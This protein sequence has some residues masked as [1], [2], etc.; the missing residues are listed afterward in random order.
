[1][2]IAILET[3]K[4]HAGFE[5]V[6]DQII[7]DELKN[8]GHEPVLFLPENSTLDVDLGVPIEYMAGGSI[9]NY[10]NIGKIHKIWRMMQR[11]IRRIKWFNA[12]YAKAQNGEVDAIILTTATYRYLR[13]LRKSKLKN[14]PIPIIFIFLGVTPMEKPYFLRE[15]RKCVGYKNIK[16]KITSLRNDFLD[17]DIDNLKIITPPVLVP[18]SILGEVAQQYQE[19]IKIGFFGHYRK[20]EKDI[21]GILHAF[22]KANL[23]GKAQLIVQAAPTSEDDAADLNKIMQKYAQESSI[24]FIKGKLLGAKWDEALQSVDVIFLPYTAQRYLYNWSAVYFNAIGLQKT[25]LVTSTLNPEV[26]AEYDIGA[27]VNLHDMEIF[28][29]QIQDFVYNYQKKIPIYESE[30]KRAN[31]AFGHTEFIRQLLGDIK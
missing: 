26:L 31:K 5:L 7:I 2:R 3:V 15:A 24:S 18:S 14:S 22:I 19:P 25:V 11:E 16:L 29:Q 28:R 13:S 23:G 1:M 27:E 12:A 20:G 21:D 10:E 4:A 17:I 8:Q 30:L 6:F 9:V